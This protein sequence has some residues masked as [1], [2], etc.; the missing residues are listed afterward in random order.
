M[1]LPGF[2][3]EPTF[4]PLRATLWPADDVP[5]DLADEPP[6]LLQYVET[7]APDH[8]WLIPASEKGGLDDMDV[9]LVT[10]LDDAHTSGKRKR[11]DDPPSENQPMKKSAVGE[12]PSDGEDMDAPDSDDREGEGENPNDDEDVDDDGPATIR[13]I[14]LSTHPT[15]AIHNLHPELQKHPNTTFIL[16]HEYTLFMQHALS[17]R[18]RCFFVTGQ[19]GIG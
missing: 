3:W 9:P 18:A 10:D 1:L 16:R 6:A 11:S 2:T 4:E 8:G 13:Y 15:L 12:P 17:S 19:P 5:R 7:L 14:N